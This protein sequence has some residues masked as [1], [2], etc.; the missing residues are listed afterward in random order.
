MREETYRSQP[1]WRITID[2]GYVDKSDRMANSYLI[3]HHTCK[4][5]KKLFFHFLDL[6]VLNSDILLLSCGSK[7]SHGDC[8]LTLMRNMVEL[9]GP[10]PCPLQSVGRASSLVTI[11]GHLEENNHQYW[12]TTTEKSMG[13][14]VFMPV[15]TGEI[16]FKQ[17]AKS[18]MLGCAYH[19]VSKA[20]T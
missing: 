12:S 10:Q 7:L 2:M 14:V 18:I 1:L 13:G 15:R 16:E 11:I 5:T 17:S 3:S 6:T 20:I 8:R 4:C 19:D 9:S